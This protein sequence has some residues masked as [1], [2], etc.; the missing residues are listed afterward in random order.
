[1]TTGFDAES[2]NFAI[3]L[4]T[5]VVCVCV[6]VCVIKMLGMLSMGRKQNLF[7]GRGGHPAWLCTDKQ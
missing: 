7:K 3:H 1:M 6:C 5:S 4:T 2:V